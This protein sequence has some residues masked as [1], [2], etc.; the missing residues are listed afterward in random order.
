MCAGSEKTNRT[1]S[2]VAGVGEPKTGAG[3]IRNSLSFSAG[4]V[5]PEA[6]TRVG[7]G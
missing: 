6:E 7:G 1:D 5:W 3:D 2:F 4:V